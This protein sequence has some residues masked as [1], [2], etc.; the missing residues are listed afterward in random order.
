MLVFDVG[1]VCFFTTLD[2]QDTFSELDEGSFDDRDILSYVHIQAYTIYSEHL[3]SSAK[4]FLFVH[5]ESVTV[6][7]YLSFIDDT[8]SETPQTDVR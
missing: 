4:C 2:L 3:T 5:Y 1:R 8:G 6:E 7:L